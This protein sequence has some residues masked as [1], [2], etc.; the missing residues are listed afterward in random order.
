[1]KRHVAALTVLLL[2]SELASAQF[3]RYVVR[4]RNKGGT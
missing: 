1:M 4:F 3:T 2:L